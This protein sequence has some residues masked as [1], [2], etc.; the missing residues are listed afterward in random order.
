MLAEQKLHIAYDDM[1]SGDPVIVLL[2]GLFANRTYYAAQVPHLSRRHR[3]LSLDLRG[4]GESD[5]PEAGYSL[6]ILADD[7]VG[8]CEQAGVT[9]AVFCGHSMAV[10]LK[11]ALRR[12]DLA[13]GVVLLDGAVLMPPEARAGLDKLA[14]ALQTDGWRQALLGY[15]PSVAGPAAERVRADISAVPRYYAEP[16]IRCIAS[17][18][19]AEELAALS[20]PLMYVHSQIPTDLEWLRRIQPD[21]TIEEIPGAGHWQMLAAPDRINA[22]LDRFLEA[23]G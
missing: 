15:F 5:I 7:V 11:A 10:A 12:P 14:R 19:S 6:D 18:D 8:V 1:G 9:R 20:C 2:H 16:I 13:A 4:H 23:I 17:S 21:A 3:V 22:L